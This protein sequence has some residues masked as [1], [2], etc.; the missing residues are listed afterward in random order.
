MTWSFPNSR[1]VHDPADVHEN[2]ADDNQWKIDVSNVSSSI[3]K[4]NCIGLDR[5]FHSGFHRSTA[6]VARNAESAK[7]CT[8][9][10]TTVDVTVW[11]SFNAFVPAVDAVDDVITH[12][13]S[14]DAL[15]RLV[16]APGQVCQHAWVMSW[17]H[18]S[19]QTRL[20]NTSDVVIPDITAPCNLKMMTLH[21]AFC[22]HVSLF[23][24][25]LAVHI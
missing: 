18:R 24:L 4:I 17:Y 10:P 20:I 9:S 11:T 7:S 23:V 25:T 2:N 15:S 3:F 16:T 5:Y 6:N 21:I 12:L 8:V 14:F 19:T 22:A 1:G 13:V